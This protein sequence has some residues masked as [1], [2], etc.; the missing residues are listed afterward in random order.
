MTTSG[1]FRGSI[2]RLGKVGSPS[3]L[4]LDLPIT[5][6]VV[7]LRMQKVMSWPTLSLT[8]TNR[9]V[10]SIESLGKLLASDLKRSK[11]ETSQV[12]RVAALIGIF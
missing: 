2:I 12:D 3:G 5:L 11:E 6:L 8:P 4:A 9:P 7:A 1:A 10:S